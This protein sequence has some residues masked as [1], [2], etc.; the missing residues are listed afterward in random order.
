[1]NRA[2]GFNSALLTFLVIMM[3]VSCGS[4]GGDSDTGT[5]GKGEPCSGEQVPGC[6]PGLFC[7]FA[8][9]VCLEEGSSGICEEVP[10]LCTL[11]YSPVCGCDGRTYPNACSAYAASVSVRY[12]G[13]C[14]NK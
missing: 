7:K 14:I 6:A 5:P 13:E 11:D 3:L 1:M 2:R 10:Q 8:E 4:S 9:G 12:A